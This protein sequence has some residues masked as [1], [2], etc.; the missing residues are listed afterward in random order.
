MNRRTTLLIRMG[1]A[2]LAVLLTTVAF[3]QGTPASASPSTIVAATPEAVVGQVVAAGD[4]VYAG[5]CSTT[6]SPEDIGKVCSK[7]VETSAGVRSY[8]TGR[9]FSE[10]DQ[11]V[12]VE[13][14]AAGWQLAGTAPLDLEATSLVIPWPAR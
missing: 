7:F 1:A 3:V 13:Q 10:F 4:D 14:T 2:V 6:R 12:F 9:T 11:W 8:L 5:D